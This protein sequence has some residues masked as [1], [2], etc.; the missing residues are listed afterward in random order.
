MILTSQAYDPDTP[1]GAKPR[2]AQHLQKKDVVWIV[3]ILAVLGVASIPL[4]RIMEGNGHKTT[5]KK[6][7]KAIYGAI[8]VYAETNDGR[9]PP[10]YQTN[11]DGTP[12]LDIGGLP[13]TW[14]TVVSEHLDHGAS[15]KCP[16]CMEGEAMKGNG[17]SYKTTMFDQKGVKENKMEL[18]YGMYAPMALRITEQLSAPD[19]TILIGET[20]N[21][22]ARNTFNPMP[23]MDR[24]GVKIPFDAFNIGWD[25]FNFERAIIESGSSD[26]KKKKTFVEE[27]MAQNPVSVT[28]LAFYE[29]QDGN[30]DGGAKARHK[31][32]IHVI[33]AD[34]HLRN[35][36]ASKAKVLKQGNR[37]TEPWRV[38]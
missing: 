17:V 29:T 33:Y 10:L 28:R 14:A 21:F 34:G 9:Y 8:Q 4:Y 6:N 5:C 27:L 35:I 20:T 32:F 7:I 1:E 24:S 12:N 26:G 2:G 31:E 23:F 13:V 25:S 38:D 19:E 18:S 30:F 22:G 11:F 37:I 16:A 15:F 36:S 3:L